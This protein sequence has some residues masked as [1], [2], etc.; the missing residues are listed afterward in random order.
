MREIALDTETTGLNP[1]AGHRMVEIGCVEMQG[2]IRTGNVFH[3]YL[4]PERDMPAEAQKVHGLSA[5][6]LSDKPLFIE[7]ADKFLDFLA[8]SPL[9][10]HN[11]SFDMGFI[12]HELSLIKRPPLSMERTIDTV[13]IARERFPGSPANLDALCRRFEIDLSERS[14]HGAL[15]DAELLADVYLELMGG[16]QSS[17]TLEQKS[18]QQHNGQ[19][20]SALSHFPYREFPVSTE[21]LSL[22]EAFLEELTEPLWRKRG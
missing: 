14:F 7:A 12:N 4:N 10:I 17:L 13:K 15:L 16:R 21:E 8:D 11:A 22:H 6:F 20:R 2:R 18:T 1:S 3:I 19:E 5:E 9:V